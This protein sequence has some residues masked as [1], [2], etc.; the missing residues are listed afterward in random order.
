MAPFS[1]HSCNHLPYLLRL[2][3]LPLPVATHGCSSSMLPNHRQSSMEGNKSIFYFYKKYL[4]INIWLHWVLVVTC[5]LPVVL[6]G[7]QLPNQGSKPGPLHREC[8]VPATGPPE[9]SQVHFKFLSANDCGAA[10][11][12]SEKSQTR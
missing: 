4:L 1:L 10:N 3:S 11:N 12:M 8:R 9:E 7:I 2:L 5:E 6:C